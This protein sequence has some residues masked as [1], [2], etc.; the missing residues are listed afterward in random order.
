MKNPNPKSRLPDI[1]NRLLSLDDKRKSKK[2]LDRGKIVINPVDINHN[3]E[4][5]NKVL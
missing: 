2:I 5:K 4:A 1:S 3:K